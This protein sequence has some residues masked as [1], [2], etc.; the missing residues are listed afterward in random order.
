M[1]RVAQLRNVFTLVPLTV[2]IL[3]CAGRGAQ[4]QAP[5][6]A[7][8]GQALFAASCSVCHTGAADSR[9]PSL[10]ALHQHSPESVIQAAPCADRARI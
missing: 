7:P 5:A 6:S 10:E 3:L 2:A 1:I 9:A 4:S 8:D